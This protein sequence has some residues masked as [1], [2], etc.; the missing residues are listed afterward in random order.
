MAAIMKIKDVETKQVFDVPASYDRAFIETRDGVRVRL[1]P[2][3]LRSM[4][5]Q[6]DRFSGHTVLGPRELVW[7]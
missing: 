6:G 5:K 3:A 1:H 4:N 2:V 7:L